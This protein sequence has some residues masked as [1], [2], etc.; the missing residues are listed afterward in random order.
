[1]L[2]F[3]KQENRPDSRVLALLVLEEVADSGVQALHERRRTVMQV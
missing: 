1:M 2:Y 3:P